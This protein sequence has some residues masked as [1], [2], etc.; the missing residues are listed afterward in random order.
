M[1]G[2]RIRRDQ[3]NGRRA[4]GLAD[5]VET[6][7]SRIAT[8]P[9]QIAYVLLAE[10]RPLRQL[11][12]GLACCDPCRPDISAHEPPHIH[13]ATV[14]RR[15][16]PSL[17]TIICIDGPPRLSVAAAERTGV[18]QFFGDFRMMI[19]LPRLGLLALISAA[20]CTSVP[21]TAA[22]QSSFDCRR[23]S[24]EAVAIICRD[25][26][27]MR[28]DRQVD[29]A[30]RSALENAVEPGRI[31]DS[32]ERWAGGIATC[33]S[34][35]RCISQGLGEEL[36]ALEYATQSATSERGEERSQSF[37]STKPRPAPA[38]GTFSAVPPLPDETENPK[39]RVV[40][41]NTTGS[42]KPVGGDAGMA[43]DQYDQPL[44]DPFAAPLEPF[45]STAVPEPVQTENAVPLTPSAASPENKNAGLLMGAL[46]LGLVVI[47]LLALLATKSL[48]DY[49]MRKYGWPMILNWWNLLHLV[50]IFALIGLWSFAAP[51]AGLVVAG[52]LWVI[53][54]V[55][56]S[57]KTNIL[58]GLAMT[59]IQP[60]VIF[61]LWA[62]Y[63]VAKAKAEGRRI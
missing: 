10:P 56:N 39:E 14:D 1:G 37:A 24:S 21:G 8:P 17:S 36:E 54:L 31:R 49:S 51:V 61:V 5:F 7:D 12:L 41:A 57:L 53:M 30:Y 25:P 45:E 26:E 32:H 33:G 58:A 40:D 55:V 28:R 19:S 18:P 34:D 38:Q 3:D 20:A 9:F 44:D 11:L 43:P 6:D 46:I 23:P 59:I 13:A 48:A 52:G 47:V 50:A 63:G 60:F 4:K 29:A 62:L 42:E 22:A 15:P 27:L 2:V 16:R 35:R